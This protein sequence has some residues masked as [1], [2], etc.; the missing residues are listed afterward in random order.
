MLCPDRYTELYDTEQISVENVTN[1]SL[2]LAANI[3]HRHITDVDHKRNIKCC[4]LHWTINKN[5]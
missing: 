4:V 2:E 1:A 3:Q 5:H